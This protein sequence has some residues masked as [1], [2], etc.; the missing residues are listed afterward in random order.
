MWKYCNLQ[1][2]PFNFSE[3][4]MQKLRL[5]W[6]YDI[7]FNWVSLENAYTWAFQCEKFVY[8]LFDWIEIFGQLIIC[9]IANKLS[10]MIC[11]F[12]INHPHPHL[13]TENGEEKIKLIGSSLS[14]VT[15]NEYIRLTLYRMWWLSIRNQFNWC[16]WQC[17]RHLTD[18]W[19]CFIIS[20]SWFGIQKITQ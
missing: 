7:Y 11:S 18:A 2:F 10:K 4:S 17:D 12:H 8:L 1:W 9:W 3:F 16:R 19:N 15:F 13:Y 20:G 14:N 6:S 5:L